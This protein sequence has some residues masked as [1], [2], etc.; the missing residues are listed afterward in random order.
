MQIVDMDLDMGYSFFCPVTGKQIIGPEH[1]E[2][3]PATAFVFS[4]DANDFDH[5]ASELQPIWDAILDGEDE[6][7][8]DFDGDQFETFR[9]KVKDMPNLVLFGLTSHGIACGPV[10][11]T[12]FIAIDFAYTGE[13]SEEQGE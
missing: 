1:F 3:S 10:S 13:E 4:A 11:S 6:D 8:E 2:A 9:E 12:V 5:L 7:D